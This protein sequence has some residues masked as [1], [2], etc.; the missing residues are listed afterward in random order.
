MQ[1]GQYEIARKIGEGGFAKTYLGKHPI[2]GTPVCLKHNIR[3]TT[4]DEELLRKEA[5]IIS[6]LMGHHSLPAF[7]DFIRHEEAYVLITSFIPGKDLARIRKE[8]YPDGI[9]PEHVCYIAQRSLNAL[10]FLHY[11]GVVHGDVKPGNMILKPE[12]QNVTLVDYGLATVLPGRYTRSPGY[13]PAF[14]APEQLEGKPPIPETDIYCLGKTL[15]DLLGGNIRSN[16]FPEGIP[17]P[18]KA[19]I[20]K[21]VREKVL[22]RPQKALPLVS[23]LVEIRK[24]VFERVQCPDVLNIS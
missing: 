3:M 23:E 7:R 1:I 5:E 15:I 18:L 10:H 13:T 6:G 4:E 22:E 16:T 12:D 20:L 24:R 9:P 14:A 17:L 2:L 21:M 11:Y 8:D 19:F